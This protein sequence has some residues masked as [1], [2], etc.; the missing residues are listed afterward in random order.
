[1]RAPSENANL[2]PSGDHSGSTT[3][4]AGDVVAGAA[5]PVPSEFATKSV[6][7]PPRARTNATFV[8]SGDHVGVWSFCR[9]VTRFA[10]VPSAPTVQI[11]GVGPA[12]TSNAIR[13][14]S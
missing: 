2:D 11:P 8:P 3:V 6:S 1:M 14:P 12:V 10:P 7:T 13:L 9:I 5:V 4:T